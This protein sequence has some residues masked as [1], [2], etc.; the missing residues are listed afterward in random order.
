MQ[1]GMTGGERESDE[2]ESVGITGLGHYPGLA[3]ITVSVIQLL[4][5][6]FVQVD[7]YPTDE[8]I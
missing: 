2:G 5:Y 4:L 3:L 1:T 7:Y 6:N 8:N